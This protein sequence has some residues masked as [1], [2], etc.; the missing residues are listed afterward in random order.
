MVVKA[1]SLRFLEVKQGEDRDK[2]SAESS[3]DWS[4]D[5]M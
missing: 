3:R 4:V 5:D 1:V 2:K